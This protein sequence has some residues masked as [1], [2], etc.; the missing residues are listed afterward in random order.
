VGGGQKVT[1]QGALAGPWSRRGVA[2]VVASD[3]ITA[4]LAAVSGS[5]R[6]PFNDESMD[7]AT[8]SATLRCSAFSSWA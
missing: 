2:G 4:L 6:L 3:S 8:A 5:Q 7:S 1:R